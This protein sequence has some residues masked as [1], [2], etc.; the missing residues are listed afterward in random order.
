M[1]RKRQDKR[2]KA[3]R[4]YS[5]NEKPGHDLEIEESDLPQEGEVGEEGDFLPEEYPI[6]E[7]YGG[8]VRS[9]KILPIQIRSKQRRE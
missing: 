5:K 3:Q 4:R 8:D 9:W 6:R 2:P 7:S 1:E